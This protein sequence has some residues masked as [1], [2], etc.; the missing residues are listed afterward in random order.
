M[1]GKS[2]AGQ[3]DVSA[4]PGNVPFTGAQSGT[5]TADAI[6]VTPHPVLRV[7]GAPA[8]TQA[9]CTFSFSGANSNGSPVAGQESVTLTAGATT[10]HVGPQTVLVDGDQAAGVFGN[11]LQVVSTRKLVTS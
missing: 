4:T 7:D 2:V 5:W 10:L 1:T 3:G 6:T 8:I 11:K 9:S